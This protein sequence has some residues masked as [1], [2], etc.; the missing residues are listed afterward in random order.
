MNDITAAASAIR[1]GKLVVYPT[2]TLYGLGADV[3]NEEAVKRVYQA[4]HRPRDRPLPVA[5]GSIDDIDTIAVINDTAWALARA[6]LPGALTVVLPKRPGVPGRVAGD[7][8]AVRVPDHEVALELCRHAG[9]ITTTSA[10]L[11]GGAAPVTIGEAREQLGDMVERYIDDGRLPGVPS[12]VV[13]VTG[14]AISIIREG[15]VKEEQ[16]YDITR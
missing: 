7:T 13:D 6:L 14:G 12:T 11:H 9:A 2:D 4:K 15:A 5:V 8:V 3:F 1:Q 10:N 16:L